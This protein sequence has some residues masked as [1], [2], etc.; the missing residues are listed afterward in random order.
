MSI[1]NPNCFVQ[2]N[3]SAGAGF[4]EQLGFFS[5]KII[6]KIKMKF[7]EEDARKI[8]KVLNAR[9]KLAKNFYRLTVG[10]AIL[11]IRSNI[12]IGKR[13]GALVSVYAPYTH[14]QLHFCTG[15]VVSELLREVTFIGEYNGKVSGLIIGK[16]GACSLYA[17]L[18]KEILRGDFTKLEPEIMISGVA[19]SLGELLLEKKSKKK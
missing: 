9:L 2:S 3:P 16:N 14:L 12:K 10:K 15:Y 18:D 8:G 6:R 7:K 19:L 4:D 11:E 1:L 17:N 5:L 13:K